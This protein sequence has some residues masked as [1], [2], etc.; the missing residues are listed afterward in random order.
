[1]LCADDDLSELEFSLF[2]ASFSEVDEAD[3][4][5]GF[6]SRTLNLKLMSS[7][8]FSL[9]SVYMVVGWLLFVVVMLLKL[10]EYEEN[11]DSLALNFLL[12]LLESSVKTSGLLFFLG[13]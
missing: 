6:F 3:M 7:L 4:E 8:M 11:T 13:F 2:T 10:L 5:E 12:L 9:S 1:M